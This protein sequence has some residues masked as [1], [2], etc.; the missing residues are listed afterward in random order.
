LEVRIGSTHD[1]KMAGKLMTVA[2]VPGWAPVALLAATLRQQRLAS[3]E[4]TAPHRRHPRP[5][6]SPAEMHEE[7]GWVWAV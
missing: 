4:S 1:T 6:P 3:I 7:A 2:C 5:M